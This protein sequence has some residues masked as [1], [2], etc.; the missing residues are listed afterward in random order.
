MNLVWGGWSGG[1]PNFAYR[2]LIMSHDINKESKQAK[3]LLSNLP[4]FFSAKHLRYT[5]R[6][7]WLPFFTCQFLLLST[8]VLNDN[9]GNL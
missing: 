2:V 4:K 5:V 9:A 7:V 6:K 8:N 3:F 1:S